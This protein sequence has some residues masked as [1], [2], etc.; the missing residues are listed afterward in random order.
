MKTTAGHFDLNTPE[1]LFK[2]AS[3]DYFEFFKKPNSWTLFNLLATFNHLV[4]W[5]CPEAKGKSPKAS[6]AH[7][8]PQQ[9]FYDQLWSKPEF[10]VIRSLCN[11]S[12]HFHHK[13]TEPNTDVINGA[14]AGRARAGD[15]ISQTYYIVDGTDIRDILI[16]VY[17][18]YKKYFCV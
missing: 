9:K 4:E 18:S 13:P 5:I 17:Q 8:T 6:Y 15:S 10:R 16:T 11:N 2:K 14:R 3:N 1:A 7:G 12:K